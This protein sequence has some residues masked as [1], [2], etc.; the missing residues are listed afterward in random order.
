MLAISRKHEAMQQIRE[1]F[2]QMAS[3]ALHRVERSRAIEAFKR[4]SDF[5]T[6]CADHDERPE[7]GFARMRS[8]SQT[9]SQP[10][11]GTYQ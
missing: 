4:D 3:R 6:L 1:S 2:M 10:S 9:A 7:A 8:V 11:S 5:R